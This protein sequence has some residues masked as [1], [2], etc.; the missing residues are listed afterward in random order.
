MK[1]KF[2]DFLLYSL[3]IIGALSLL[4]SASNYN[5]DIDDVVDS[6]DDI[7]SALNGIESQLGSGIYVYE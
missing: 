3:A 6:L 7:R 4:I 5:D 1:T 2:K